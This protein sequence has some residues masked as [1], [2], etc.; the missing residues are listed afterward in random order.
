MVNDIAEFSIRGDITDIFSL[1][2]NPVRIEFWGDEIV[3]IRYIDRET[4]KS[5]E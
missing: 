4:Q 2:N 3:D 5:I 1:Q